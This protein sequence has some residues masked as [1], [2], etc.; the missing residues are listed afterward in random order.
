[1]QLKRGLDDERNPVYTAAGVFI[2][3]YARDV[4]IRAAQANYDAFAYAD[5]DSLHLL[6]RDIVA[7]GS[8]E[9]IRVHPTE[10]GAWKHEYDFDAA[11]YIRAKAYFERTSEGK[12][13]NAVAGIPTHISGALTFDHLTP[14]Q[15]ITVTHRG[16][17]VRVDCAPWPSADSVL[18][19]GKL[20]PRTVPGGVVLMPT[21]YELKLVG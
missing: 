7:V 8:N 13:H 6:G 18:I 19:H 15:Q 14:G 5:T 3:S 10:L 9:G 17:E 12:F 1:M 2:T 16:D 20:T 11:H 21:P 4:T